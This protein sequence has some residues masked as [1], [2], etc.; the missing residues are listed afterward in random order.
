MPLR[1]RPAADG[2]A[3]T[4]YVPIWRDP[5]RLVAVVMR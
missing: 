5:S 1:V 3:A 2:S 4:P